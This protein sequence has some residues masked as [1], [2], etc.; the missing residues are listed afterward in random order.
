MGDR[1]RGREKEGA[2]GRLGERARK[3][4]RRAGRKKSLVDR[5]HCHARE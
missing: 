4:H 5:E 1:G 2:G 3:A